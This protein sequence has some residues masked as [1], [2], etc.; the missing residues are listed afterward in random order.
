[1][2]GSPVVTTMYGLSGSEDVAHEVSGT[3]GW[4]LGG[5]FALAAVTMEYPTSLRSPVQP[6]QPL[7]TIC[8]ASRR[9]VYTTD[10]RLYLIYAVAFTLLRYTELTV[11]V[12]LTNEEEVL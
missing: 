2:A 11:V 4:G 6:T 9:S 7:P 1:M 8:I 12:V 3:C 10:T 5:A